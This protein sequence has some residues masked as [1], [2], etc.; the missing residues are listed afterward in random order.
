MVRSRD[1]ILDIL[2]ER[3]H[4]INPY[5]RT[6]VLKVWSRL[7]ETGSLPVKRVGNVAQIAVDRLND[8]NAGVRRNAVVL[9]TTAIEN[10]PFSGTLDAALFRLQ[11]TEL[12]KAMAAR[13]EELHTAHREANGGGA[14]SAAAGAGKEKG[15]GRGASK[16]ADL[17]AITEEDEEGEEGSD[18]EEGE[19]VEGNATEGMD[20]SDTSVCVR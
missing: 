15:K 9:M 2:I 3:A 5:T 6:T 8:K 20:C 18:E 11:Q 7:L 16:G 13:L 12:L 14:G 10:N 19:G 17:K 1:V 4:D